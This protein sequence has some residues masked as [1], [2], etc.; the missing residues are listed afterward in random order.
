MRSVRLRL[1]FSTRIRFASALIFLIRRAACN[2]FFLLIFFISRAQDDPYPDSLKQALVTAPEDSNKVRL[3]ADLGYYY[4]WSQPDTSLFYSMPGLALAR[5]LNFDDGEYQLML[6]L[7]EAL[8]MKGNYSQALTFRF[9]ATELAGRLKDSVK[10]A[11]SIALTGNVYLYAKEYEKALEYFYKAKATNKVRLGGPKILNGFIGQA[12]LYSGNIDS[13]FVY[14]QRAYDEDLRDTLFHW[15]PPYQYLA[16]IY[17]KKGNYTKSLELYRQS[18]ELTYENVDRLRNA[19][20]M[21]LVFSKTGQTDSAIRYAKKVV[22]DGQSLSI[23]APVVDAS[24]LLANIYKSTGNTDSAFKYQEVLLTTKDSLFSQEKVKQLQN[25]AFDEQLH[26]QERAIEKDKLNNRI[27]LYTLLAALALFITIGIALWKNNR[28]KQKANALL[29][30]KNKQVESTLKELRSTQA[31]LIQREK[32]A[33]LGELTAGI[34][35]EIQNPL[36]FVNNFSELN[37]ELIS[38]LKNEL[39][40]GNMQSVAEIT[41]DIELNLGK[42]NH[43]GKRAE[44]IVKG[45]LEHSLGSSGTKEPTDINRLV[46]EYL[47]LAYNSYRTKEAQHANVPVEIKFQSDYDGSIGQ[48]KLVAADIGRVVLNIA[49]NAFYAVAARQ[50][51]ATNAY[52]PT[53]S[54]AT[55]KLNNS[56][57]IKISDNGTGIPETILHKIF[58][59]FFTTKPTGRGT[60]LGLSLS[61]EIIKAHGG[62]IKADSTEGSGTTFTIQLPVT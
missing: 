56:I 18:V 24:S 55:K 9:R 11:N 20:G 7:A 36:N 35:H 40:E 52:E 60:G 61:Y 3:Y 2:I 28:S 21:A 27:K 50:R 4:Q 1:S 33:S 29:D 30:S 47:R 42:I 34:A 6:P 45:M 10:M 62:E 51:S 23:L 59:P 5:R 26:Q 13:A 25:V 48:I 57:E 44:A 8:S 17:E 32:M 58:Q 38:E 22:A 49:G 41:G 53:I 39:R 31:Q 54:I 43:H 37:G 16:A 15:G 12:Y 14:I 19:N 46:E